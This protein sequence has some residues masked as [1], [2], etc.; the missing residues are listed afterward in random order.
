MVDTTK[1]FPP[2]QAGAGLKYQA[3]KILAHQAT[4]AFMRTHS[5]SFDLITMHPTFVLGRSLVQMSAAG[6]DGINAWLWSSLNSK[7]AQFASLC[8]HVR[9]VA[10]AHVKALQRDVPSGTAFLLSGPSFGWDDVVK[11]VKSEYEGKIDVNLIG[12][13]SEPPVA[14]ASKAERLLGMT[15]RSMEEI[16]GDVLDQQLDFKKSSL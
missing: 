4:L 9:D 12:P 13:F 6:I 5:P 8:V 15:W 16:V 14:D 2:G 11:F 10:E 7:K 3:S 1:P